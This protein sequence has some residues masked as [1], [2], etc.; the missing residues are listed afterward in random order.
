[1]T[2]TIPV[3]ELID[4]E[5]RA[6]SE[7][8]QQFDGLIVQNATCPQCKHQGLEFVPYTRAF[9]KSYRAFAVCPECGYTFE[10]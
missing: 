2:N 10:F 4:Y 6:P 9:P 7:D 1:M 8:A 5:Q 3:D